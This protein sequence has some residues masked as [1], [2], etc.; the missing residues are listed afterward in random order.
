MSLNRSVKWFVALSLLVSSALTSSAMPVS[1]AA[2]KVDTLSVNRTQT[3][4]PDPARMG[5]GGGGFNL[6]Q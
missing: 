6:W 4:P 3:N 2:A 1:F 5:G